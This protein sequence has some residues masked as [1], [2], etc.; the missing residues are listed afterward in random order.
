MSVIASLP[1]PAAPLS[2]IIHAC[3]CVSV[4]SLVHSFTDV[5]ELVCSKM[6]CLEREIS[7]YQSHVTALKA[8]LHDACI[9][10][11]QCYV[12]LFLLLLLLQLS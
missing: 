4:K 1:V 5:Y 9:R 10:E 3:V 8:E 2:V 6:V 7:S 12:S 11:N